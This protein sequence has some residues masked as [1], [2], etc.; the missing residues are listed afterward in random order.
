MV[1]VGAGECGARAAIALRDAGYSGPVC[2]IGREAHLP[3]E[4][5]PL[6]KSAITNADA[7]Q[8]KTIASEEWLAGAAITLIVR[9]PAV[10]INREKRTV[11]L[12]DRTTLPY[13]K[14][15]LATGAMPRR[16]PH[17]PESALYLRTFDDA[18]AIRSRLTAG[19][20]VTIVGGGFLGLELAASARVR[21]ADVTVIE[22]QPRLLMRGVPQEIAAAIEAR[23]KAEG[24]DILCSQGVSE[25]EAI[26]SSV[27][28]RTTRGED[29]ES[30][31]CVIGIGVDPVTELAQRAGLAIENGIAVD[32]FL[33]TSD[34]DIFAAGDCCSAPLGVYDSRRFRIEAWRNAQEQGALAAANMLGGGRKHTA[35]PWFWS[36]QYEMTL[37]VAG[38]PE[39]GC[40]SVRR[41]RAD[42]ALLLFHLA[43][44]GRLVAASGIGAGNAV[45]KDVRLAEML[46]AKRARPSPEQLMAA[47][48]TLKALLAR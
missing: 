15:L 45:A 4:R 27:H 41:E 9:N 20:R 7:P 22:A 40:V 5:P 47:R 8:P 19:C 35:V 32:E 6:S 33:R 18:V 23:H 31:L 11:E 29:I 38:L 14:L 30:D 3:Y 2:L 24:V 21:R 26:G 42:G 36:D 28:L 44:D 25:I 12:A 48:V 46:I 37:H 13:Q 17:A 34:P 39:E 16:L 10:R 1:I 43:G